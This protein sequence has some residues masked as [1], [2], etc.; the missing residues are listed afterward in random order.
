MGLTLP[1][2]PTASVDFGR[3]NHP[4][5]CKRARPATSV[6]HA[7]H[8]VGEAGLLGEEGQDGTAPTV[9]A[10]ASLRRGAEEPAPSSSVD[11]TAR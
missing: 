8:E 7:G 3:K 10:R 11:P 1:A 5:V 6:L 2:G 4:P 9:W